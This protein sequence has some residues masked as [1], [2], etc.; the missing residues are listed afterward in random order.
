MVRQRQNDKNNNKRN[1]ISLLQY[2]NKSNRNK[3]NN[4][5]SDTNGTDDAT[6]T[7]AGKEN[8][9]IISRRRGFDMLQFGCV[10]TQTQDRVINPNWILLDTCSTDNVFCNEEL[11]TNIQKCKGGDGLEIISNGGFATYDHVAHSTLLSVPVFF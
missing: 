4:T 10:L 7:I 11:V 3:G 9:S 5:T 8:V 2:N 6:E 1:S